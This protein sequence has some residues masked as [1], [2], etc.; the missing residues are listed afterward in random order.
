MFIYTLMDIH[1]D[2]AFLDLPLYSFPSHPSVLFIPLWTVGRL[3]FL[4]LPIFYP[5]S[6]FSLFVIS[7]IGR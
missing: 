7:A 3:N 4:D 6:F 2:P 1:M 5:G